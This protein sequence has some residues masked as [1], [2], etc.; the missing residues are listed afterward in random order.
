MASSR[1]ERTCV[2]NFPSL[3]KAPKTSSEPLNSVDCERPLF[4]CLTW[5]GGDD[6]PP[7]RL[8][9]AVPIICTV[10]VIEVVEWEG[11]RASANCECNCIEGWA[12]RDAI[13]AIRRGLMTLEDDERP[14]EGEP[15]A[16]G[17]RSSF[18]LDFVL[19]LSRGLAVSRILC[20]LSLVALSLPDLVGVV[21]EE[22]LPKS[23]GGS[24]EITA[25]SFS[26]A[27]RSTALTSLDECR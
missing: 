23:I 3:D 25:I 13:E 11:G 19:L 4:F 2:G 21:C 9:G 8:P 24:E 7:F 20:F 26:L 27:A 5:V 15:D 6:M 17:S 14:D 10:E 16:E 1:S 18:E 12:L 22:A